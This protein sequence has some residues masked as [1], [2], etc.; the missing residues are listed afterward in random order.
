MAKR[1]LLVGL[2]KYKYVRPLR[3]CINDVRNM[4]DILTSF[5]DFQSD[6]IRTIVDESVTR[7][8]LM[9][10]F[11]WL[12]YGAQKG[13]LLLFHF[14][15]HGS[16][17]PDRDGDELEDGMDEILCLYDMDFRNPDSY[18]SDDDFNNIIDRLPKNVFLTVCIDSCNSGTATRDLTLLTSELQVPLSD[19]KLQPRFIEP[20]ADIA[21][22]TYG[23]TVGIRR[24]GTKIKED[25]KVS[26]LE[27]DAKAKHILL[28]GCMDD[29]TSADAFIANDYNGAFTYNLC[30]TIRDMRGELTYSK[31]VQKVQNSLAFN[32][33][34]QVPQLNGNEAL[35]KERFL[36]AI[37]K[38]ELTCEHDHPLVCSEGHPPK[39]YVNPKDQE[40][41][42]KDSSESSKIA[43]RIIISTKRSK[44][45][46]S[47]DIILPFTS[48]FIGTVRDLTKIAN[49]KNEV[50]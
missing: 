6:E 25:K 41:E 31:L 8:N 32:S 23:G 1:A 47:K 20:P 26:G 48:E 3:G 39:G 28:S 40:K 11:D 4:A 38:L 46:I 45:A 37:A 18:L 10:R 13:D 24:L 27:N 5:Y 35:K 21:L 42:K 50:G 19:M 15:G 44:Y 29:Q 9:N 14:S 17:M 43:K 7:N 36:S 33:F 2:N 12:L 22:R 30:K 34:S 16:Q 49:F